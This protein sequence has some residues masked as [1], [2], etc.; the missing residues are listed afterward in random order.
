[1]FD[2]YFDEKIFNSYAGEK[3]FISRKECQ[4]LLLQSD[5]YI[6]HDYMAC[7]ENPLNHLYVKF[8]LIYDTL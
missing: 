2:K 7:Q 1:M 8:Q 3:G 5:I 6:S 4:Q